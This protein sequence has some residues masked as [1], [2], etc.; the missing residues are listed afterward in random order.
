[1]TPLNVNEIYD[2]EA[3][4]DRR[5][6]EQVL[7]ALAL[8]CNEKAEHVVHS[9]QDATLAKRWVAVGTAIDLITPNGA[10]L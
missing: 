2:L 1:M 5:G 6:I 7:V 3:L 10:G 4:I 8:I 9:W